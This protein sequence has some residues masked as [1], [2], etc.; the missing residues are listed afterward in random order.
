METY[1]HGFGTIEVGRAVIKDQYKL[2]AYQNHDAEL[3][4]LEA[5]P[6]ELVNLYRHPLYEETVVDLEA[7]LQEWLS[8]TGDDDFNSPIS[9]A[10]RELDDQR[11]RELL[12]RR[13]KVNHASS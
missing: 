4:N 12:E 5:D 13:T 1:G 6:Y 7:E 10:F 11:F 8:K 2:I 3:Y 9:D